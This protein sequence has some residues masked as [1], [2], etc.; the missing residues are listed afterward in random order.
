MLERVLS[1][2]FGKFTKLMPVQEEAIPILMEGKNIIISSGTGTGKTEAVL[3]PLISRFLDYAISNNCITWL[4]I[5]PTKALV[6]DIYR[7]I[8]PILSQLHL[9]VGIRHGDKDETNKSLHFLI[10]TPESLDV[11]MCRG[12]KILKSVKT[13]ILDEVHMLYNTQRGLQTS[14]LV[15]R[16]NSQ[17]VNPPL[18]LA[19]LSATI[20]SCENILNFLFG[21]NDDFVIV[22]IP[23]KRPIDA[24][25]RMIKSDQ[26][27]VELMEKIIRIGPA[28]LLVFA[29]SRKK[30][31]YLSTLLSQSKLLSM[32]TLVHYSSLST[33]LREETERKFNESK[34]AIC[35]ATSTLELGID[36]GDIDAVILYGT[37]FTVSSF[38]Q[39]IGRGNRRNKKSNAIC[40]VPPDSINPI[41]EAL[42]FYSIIELA[43]QGIMEQTT[44]MQ[45]FG[46]MA[47]QAISIIASNKGAYTRVKD[48]AS[49][50]ASHKHLTSQVI[51]NILA[52]AYRDGFIKPH[53][54]KHSY[55]ADEGLYSLLDHRLI[56]SNLPMKSQEIVIEH[57]DKKIGYISVDNL[58]KIRLGMV[59]RFAG[60]HWKVIKIENNRIKV[61]SHDY[62]RDALQISYFSEGM[63]SIDVIILK[64]IYEYL[65]GSYVDTKLFEKRIQNQI[66]L[67]LEASYRIFRKS[68][69]P[70]IPLTK[71]FYHITFAGKICNFII[72]KSIG[73][74]KSKVND[75][76]IFAPWIID[77]SKLKSSLSYYTDIVES[78]F[79]ASLSQTL[80]Q[81]HLPESLQQKEFVEEWLCNLEMKKVLERLI[82]SSTIEVPIERVAFL[83]PLH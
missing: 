54:Y 3:A 30:C 65:S 9:N 63:K 20:S 73:L 38:L 11:I 74:F 34:T 81:S 78:L 49:I 13:V 24:T 53:G 19:C 28:K 35:V 52:S 41:F 27:L 82:T 39:R 55:G 36:I 42:Q 75:V 68:V 15:S 72:S 44:P 46:A 21:R 2:F 70:V 10:T 4:Y 43:S 37:P 50:S 14:L 57:G 47:Q 7:R 79:T 56:Y 26:E 22:D 29:N 32:C 8:E 67:V 51:D 69:V 76:G 6:N 59:I 77:F 25:I 45:L 17:V 16:L 12:D 64:R 62:A 48:I 80:F 1:A 83:F 61:E 5:T 58:L 40:I 23:S 66:S 71:E 33:Q 18:Q 31:D 60:K